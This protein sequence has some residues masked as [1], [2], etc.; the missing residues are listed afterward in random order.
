MGVPPVASP[1]LMLLVSPPASAHCVYTT[2]NPSSPSI[3]CEELC[4]FLLFVIPVKVHTANDPSLPTS[5]SCLSSN[6]L[7]NSDSPH[8]PLMSSLPALSFGSS[9]HLTLSPLTCP[10]CLAAVG[11]PSV[12]QLPGP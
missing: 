8:P 5:L 7:M 3:R 10:I 9:L 4:L 6:S 2:P 1:T 11:R 12:I